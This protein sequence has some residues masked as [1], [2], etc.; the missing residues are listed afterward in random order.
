[1][2]VNSVMSEIIIEE[3]VHSYY[4]DQWEQNA[5]KWETS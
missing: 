1:M 4:T 3:Y 2:C 5:S